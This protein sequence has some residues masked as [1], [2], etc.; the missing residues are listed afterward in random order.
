MNT[1]KTLY[2]APKLTREKVK[3]AK[4]PFSSKTALHLKKSATKFLRVCSVHDKVVTGLYLSV[5]KW[6]AR[7]GHPLLRENVV[8]T[9]QPIQKCKF[10]MN[11]CS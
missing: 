4:W 2:V 7:G 5:Q 11:I 8:K 3:N 9:D 1:R 6:F 10:P